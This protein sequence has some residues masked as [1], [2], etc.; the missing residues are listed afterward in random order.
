MAST[1]SRPSS[2]SQVRSSPR[3]S[4]VSS[5]A[6]RQMS[7]S[8]Q[9]GR[10]GW[11]NGLL[12]RWWKL[13]ASRQGVQPADL[14]VESRAR[15]GPAFLG[16]RIARDQPEFRAVALC[17]LEIIEAGP[18]KIAA[19]RRAGFDGAKHR[20]NMGQ[21]VLRAHRVLVVGD[22]ILRHVDRQLLPFQ[23]TQRPVEALG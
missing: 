3:W 12:S 6:I 1:G 5:S 11:L 18:V 4:T 19:H 20:A 7:L 8:A 16:Q 17:P 13:D 9:I 23:P 2:K 15:A 22:A 21:D 10:A 14:R